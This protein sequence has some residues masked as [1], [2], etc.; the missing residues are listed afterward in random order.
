MALLHPPVSLYTARI[1]YA[2][3]LS[4]AEVWGKK[5]K[6]ERKKQALLATEIHHISSGVVA[7]AHLDAGLR[8]TYVSEAIRC[9]EG[10]SRKCAPGRALGL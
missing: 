9:R 3:V 7:L 5:R 1:H 10:I 8:G 2:D 6:R 4:H